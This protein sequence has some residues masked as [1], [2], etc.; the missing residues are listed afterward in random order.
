MKL[1]YRLL[2]HPFYQSWNQGTVSQEQ[3]SKYSQSYMELVENMPILWDRAISGLNSQSELAQEVINDETEHIGL[4]KKWSEKLMKAESFP[5]MEELHNALDAMNPS[6]LLGAIHSFEVQ[7]PEV[8]V[9]KKKGLI[10]HYGFA[11][12]D[13]TYFDDHMEEQKHIAFGQ[14]LYNTVSD[15]KE[16]EKGFERGSELF[17]RA[18]D[19]FVEC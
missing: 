5:R 15:K 10:E 13:L 4:W 9:T 12:K 11:D 1:K 18:L 3:L 6:E 8:A 2:D 17:Y 7:Q 16:F 14:K 19:N